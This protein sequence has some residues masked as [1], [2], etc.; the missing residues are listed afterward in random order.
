MSPN[1]N[2]DLN[3]LVG[4]M[5]G[6]QGIPPRMSPPPVVGTGTILSTGQSGRS[7]NGLRN[8]FCCIGAVILVTTILPFVLMGWIFSNTDTVTK[9]AVNMASNMSTQMTDNG[10]LP[11][12]Q[13]TIA[14]AGD[15]T[16]FDPIV[17]YN[18]AAAFAG[19]GVKLTSLEAK[20]VKSDGTVDLNA[21][22]NPQ[23]D[24]EFVHELSEPPADA[25]PVGAG[26]SLDDK[27]YESVT[28]SVHDPG[29]V[30]H[31]TSMGGNFSYSGSYVHKGMERDVGR[32]T[33]KLNDKLLDPPTCSFADFWK[34]ALG[35]GAQKD[36]VATISY[37]EHGYEFEI[38][39]TK[40]DLVFGNDCQ[41]NEKKSTFGKVPADMTEDIVVPVEPVDPNDFMK[42][43]VPR[44]PKI[45]IPPMN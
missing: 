6:G 4:K 3:N 38:R 13:N 28:I 45:P 19:G 40:I 18:Q 14:V 36:A 23:V 7:S 35:K 21:S 24:Y 42:P 32:A 39:D 30:M 17:G 34:V 5:G 25:P 44:P 16:K 33:S 37:D 12:S 41:L 22:Y 43:A 9:F 8:F 1:S 29:Q 15:V 26:G 10:F 20:Y 31:V 2:D 27:W 11:E